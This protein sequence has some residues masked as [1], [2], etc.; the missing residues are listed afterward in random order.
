MSESRSDTVFIRNLAVQTIIGIHP[1]E[2]TTPQTV[3][4]SLE[5]ETETTTAAAY[6]DIAS[7]LDYDV[8]AQRV[9]EFVSQAEFQLIETLAESLAALVL[10]NLPVAQVLVEVQ[11]PGAI[12]N[13][14]T[15]GVRIQRVRNH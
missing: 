2:R 7:A 11:K 6:D 10:E 13:A 1:H 14:E 4:I 15:V 9:T 3:L 8:L 12:S 5:L